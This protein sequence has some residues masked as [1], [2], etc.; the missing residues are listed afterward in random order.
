MQERALII[1]ARFMRRWK[2]AYDEVGLRAAGAHRCRTTVE[3]CAA[4][5]PHSAAFQAIIEAYREAIH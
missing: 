5:T 4:M 2:A 3:H 1:S